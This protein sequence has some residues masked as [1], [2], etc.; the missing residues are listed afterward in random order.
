MEEGFGY[1]DEKQ[2]KYNAAIKEVYD[3]Q[4]LFSE[5]YKTALKGKIRQANW[6]LDAIWWQLAPDSGEKEY[7]KIKI[8]NN[9]IKKSQ[10]NKQR[11]WEL[12]E[13]KYIFLKTLQ[14][15]QGKGTAYQEDDEGL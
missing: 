10:R 13:K 7:L 4:D 11:L 15:E 9:L 12:F 8:L 1:S 14:V 3:L 6:I 5:S 2:S